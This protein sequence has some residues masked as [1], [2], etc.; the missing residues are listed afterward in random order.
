MTTGTNNFLGSGF[1]FV[2]FYLC[3]FCV[4]HCTVGL[5]VF[6]YVHVAFTYIGV[7]QVCGD[8]QPYDV[9]PGLHHDIVFFGLELRATRVGLML[10]VRFFFRGILGI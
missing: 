10:A 9:Q 5:F 7:V 1:G 3:G 4:I 2:W 8:G 6:I